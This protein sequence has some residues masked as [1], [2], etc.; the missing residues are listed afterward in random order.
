MDDLRDLL[1]AQSGA[2]AVAARSGDYQLLLGAGAS[3]GAR[4]SRGALLPMAPG[5]VTML[6][7]QYPDA[8]IE[9]DVPLQRAYQRAVNEVGADK[10]W[11]F[12]KGIFGST[13]HDPWFTHLAALPWGRIWTLNVD[14]AFERAFRKGERNRITELQVIDWS[15][16]YSE[17]DYVQIVHLHGSIL[18]NAPSPLV[19]SFSEYASLAQK[20]PVWDSML[21]GSVSSKPFIIVGAKGLGEPDM[22]ATLVNNKPAATAPS[23][24]VDPHVTPGQRKEFAG[25][26]YLVFEGTAEQFTEQWTQLVE[27][28]NANLARLYETTAISIPQ[29]TELKL[30]SAPV[31]SRNHDLLGG[32]EPL[33][34]DARIGSIAQFDWMKQVLRPAREWVLNSSRES[35][36]H[37]VFG[38]RLTGL[39][40]GLLFVAAELRRL[41]ATVLQFDRVA[42][43][44]RKR[45][46]DFCTGRGP[47]VV[48]CDASHEFAVFFNDLLKDAARTPDCD[49][50]ILFGEK[51]FHE[52]QVDNHFKSNEIRRTTTDIFSRRNKADAH[53]IVGLLDRRGRLGQLEQQ[54]PE[55]RR[56]HF[57]GRDIFSAMA[58]VER[59][60]GFQQRLGTELRSLK[61]TWH[62]DLLLMLAIASFGSHQVSVQEAAFGVQ[63]STQQLLKECAENPS[64]NAL[65]EVAGDLIFARQRSSSLERL[66]EGTESDERLTALSQVT[67]ALSGLATSQGLKEK[68]RASSLVGGL[69][70]ARTLRTVFPGAIIDRYYEALFPEFAHWNARYWEQRA[71]NAKLEGKWGPAESWASRAV[72][73]KDDP[74]TRTTLGTILI[75]KA[76]VLAEYGDATWIDLYR[77]GKDELDVALQMDAGNRVAAVSFLENTLQ[78]LRST[79]RASPELASSEELSVIRAD[80]TMGYANVQLVGS[81][82]DS[83]RRRAT[84][85]RRAFDALDV[86]LS[87]GRTTHSERHANTTG[88]AGR[89]RRGRGRSSGH[90]RG[91]NGDATRRRGQH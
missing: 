77:R 16:E 55:S 38:E 71:I 8:V 28:D 45:V 85:L 17:S 24:I 41:G 9:D 50:L 70:V 74:Y 75:N 26:G 13:N 65:V 56:S 87:D 4:N 67:R 76:S 79:L 73:L 5:L 64:L 18:G 30:E 49:L 43:F 88:A 82:E 37:V 40:S 35:S 81:V 12:L 1:G 84:E 72:T 14:D 53:Q 7:R 34:N 44:E 78:L 52:L 36:L 48:V 33:W 3:F 47:V 91:Q 66:F 6:Q 54:S 42:R 10:V 83:A 23:I 61:T 31:P 21:K 90:N 19:F 2:A 68:N 58:E 60:Q 80:W 63:V 46:I 20:R 32:S 57:N 11:R 15:D 69:M 27:L 89:S 51:R 62:R 86:Q 29:F 39:S 59:G 22:E 25:L